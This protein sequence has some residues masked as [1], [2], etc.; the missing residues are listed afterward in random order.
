MLCVLYADEGAQGCLL[1]SSVR[2]DLA[3]DLPGAQSFLI[4]SPKM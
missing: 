1:R 4:V 3:D 2:I